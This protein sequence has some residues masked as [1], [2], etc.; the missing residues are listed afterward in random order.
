MHRN[1]LIFFQSMG[2]LCVQTK[3]RCFVMIFP[4][5]M[6]DQ[7]MKM[8]YWYVSKSDKKA[9]LTF[10][11]YGFSNSHDV[12]L[13]ETDEYNRYPIQ[14]YDYI[15]SFLQLENLDVLEVGSGRG[16]GAEYITRSFKPRSYQGLDL[17]SG[18]VKF[19]NKHYK[20]DALSFK[21]GNALD[22]PF[23]DNSFDVV[24]NVESSHRYPNV[25]RFFKE[26]QRVLKP[27]GHF[28]YTDFTDDF[29]VESLHRK[30]ETSDMI[31]KKHEVIT[32]AVLKALDLDNDRRKMLIK[33]LA[34]PMTRGVAKAF[35]GIKGSEIY[36]MFQTGKVEYFFYIMRKNGLAVTQDDSGTRIPVYENRKPMQAMETRELVN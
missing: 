16:G 10:M 34:L 19:C 24:I 28:L 33:R 8:W 29:L 1:R 17:C 13:G 4:K 14:L 7:F 30:L 31:M 20:H 22:M 15:V 27:N 2:I 21:Q 26:V 6:V 23:K 36:S 25:D 3:K 18:A 11:N 12:D 5:I 9:M 32:P 35:S